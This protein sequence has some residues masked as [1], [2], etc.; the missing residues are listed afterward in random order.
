MGH[1]SRLFQGVVGLTALI[2]ICLGAGAA[3][4]QQA[5]PGWIADARTGCKVWNSYPEP[6]ETISWS[7]ACAN[8]LAQGSGVLQWFASGKPGSKYSGDYSD[9]KMYGRGIVTF[10]NGNRYDGEWRDNKA[11]G[12]GTKTETNGQVYAGVWSKGCFRQG[13]RWIVVNAT[14]KECGVK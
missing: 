4:A 14:V 1:C 2:Y 13:D 3:V 9:G 11:H 10:A 8:G 7:G 5:P 6:N 12:Q